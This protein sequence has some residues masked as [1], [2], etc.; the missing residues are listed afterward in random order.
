MA[1]LPLWYSF[2]WLLELQSKSWASQ[3]LLEPLSI[4]PSL[5]PALLSSLPLPL[6]TS[7]GKPRPYH[8]FPGELKHGIYLGLSTAL[9][10]QCFGD[11]ETRKTKV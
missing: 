4:H 9:G 8:A 10:N 5:C 2:E 7:P 11:L 6:Q 1:P 3:V